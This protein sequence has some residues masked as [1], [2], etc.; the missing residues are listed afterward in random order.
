M[1][2][3]CPSAGKVVCFDQCL[4][5]PI[6]LPSRSGAS[7]NV[8]AG[9]GKNH[10]AAIE[11]EGVF[12]ELERDARMLLDQ[13][14]GELVLALQPVEPGQQRVDDDRAPAP[15]AARP[16]AAGA[17]CP[18]ARGR[19]ASIC[20]SPPDSSLPRLRRRS[21]SARKEIVDARRASSGPGRAA[22]VRFSSTRQRRERSRAPAAR[23][24]CRARERAIGRQRR[25]VL[26]AKRMRAA[27]QASCGP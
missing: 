20:C 11:D 23:S 9:S 14:D 12:G 6:R 26:A 24:R 18:S 27:M 4:P 13:Q 1:V 17:D 7:S 15:R 21:A 16:S 2:A 3:S 25:D 10:R 22:T 19:C 8:A 5:M